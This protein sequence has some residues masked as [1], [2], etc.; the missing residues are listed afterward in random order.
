MLL[1]GFDDDEVDGLSPC[2]RCFIVT[3]LVLRVL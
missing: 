1:P 2:Q 3:N